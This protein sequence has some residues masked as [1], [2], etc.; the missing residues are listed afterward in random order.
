MRDVC[1]AAAAAAPA[2]L[3]HGLPSCSTRC[4]YSLWG[5][6]HKCGVFACPDSR[7]LLAVQATQGDLVGM[8][9]SL[10]EDLWGRAGASRCETIAKRGPQMSQD[11]SAPLICSDAFRRVR[12]W[13][14][15]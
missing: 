2:R 6:G 1:K 3:L 12:D 15:C 5:S 7:S 13:K 10:R 14:A 11:V 4:S 9:A 8:H